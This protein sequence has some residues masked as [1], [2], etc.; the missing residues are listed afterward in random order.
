MAPL[1]G[2]CFVGS[3]LARTPAPSVRLAPVNA[4]TLRPAEPTDI[5]AITSLALDVFGEPG[6]DNNFMTILANNMLR[7]QVSNLCRIRVA[8]VLDLTVTLTSSNPQVEQGYLARIALCAQSRG[9]DHN[10]LVLMDSD[11]TNE[12]GGLCG[13]VELS[14]Q[15]R[16]ATA[17]AMPTPLDVKKRNARRLQPYISNLVVSP[18]MRRKGFAQRLVRACEARAVAWGFNELTLHV[19]MEE[20]AATRLY[21]KLGYEKLTDQ[22]AWQKLLSGVRLRYMSKSLRNTKIESEVMSEVEKSEF[23]AKFPFLDL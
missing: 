8:L 7:A 2:L 4:L 21:N 11:R 10:V 22:A 1:F 23:F 12:Y 6:N 17:P 14:M 5:A 13:M 16:S 19:D 20:L 9:L 3:L 15:P 18:L